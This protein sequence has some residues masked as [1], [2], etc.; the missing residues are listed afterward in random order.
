VQLLHSLLENEAMRVIDT[1]EEQYH[2]LLGILSPREVTGPECRNFLATETEKHFH[3]HASWKKGNWIYYPWKDTLVHVLSK[4]EYIR[5]RT[6]RNRHL[7]SEKE[8]WMCAKLHI[9]IIG[10]SVGSSIAQTLVLEGITRT[11]TL[12]DGDTLALSNLNRILAGITDFSVP[13]THITAQRLSEIDPY[14]TIST[15]SEL[16]EEN[17]DSILGSA[18]V[19][20]DEIDNISMKYHI[21]RVA[22]E[23]KIPVIMATDNGEQGIIDVERYDQDAPPLPFNGYLPALPEE[24]LRSLSKAEIGKLIIDFIGTKYVSQRM[25]DSFI[26]I[27]QRLTTWPQLGGTAFLNASMVSHAIRRIAIGAPLPSGRA[28]VARDEIFGEKI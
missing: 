5:V 8:Q 9:A 2:E 3:N 15:F 26:D 13:K 21:R 25:L 20:I 27:G 14:L 12:A 18:D 28:L 4:E 23:R 19:I 7:I 16:T 6:S 1:Y 10:L 17:S 22:K 11:L 24:Q